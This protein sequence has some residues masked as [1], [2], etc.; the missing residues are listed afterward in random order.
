M[1]VELRYK[2]FRSCMVT[3]RF[4]SV[5]PPLRPLM[6]SPSLDASN[7]ANIPVLTEDILAVHQRRA[8]ETA[9]RSLLL[10]P[11]ISQT[12]EGFQDSQS[13]PLYWHLSAMSCSGRAVHMPVRLYAP[14]CELDPRAMCDCRVRAVRW[15]IVLG[16]SLQAL[17]QTLR[18]CVCV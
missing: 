13:C 17:A 5:A 9:A 3:S 1:A 11:R 8:A 18:W 6:R 7:I 15:C 10:C 4:W 14:R 2:W 16:R 12:R